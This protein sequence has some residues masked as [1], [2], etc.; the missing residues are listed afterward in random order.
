MRIVMRV[1][2][3]HYVIEV[4]EREVVGVHI[5]PSLNTALIKA[6]EL[7]DNRV[8]ETNCR[9]DADEWRCATMDGLCAWCNH[10]G[11]WD[12][13]IVPFDNGEKENAK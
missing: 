8:N 2:T 11:L 4:F 10:D 9:E 1:M 13:H 5:L 12:A 7:L 6:N 3:P